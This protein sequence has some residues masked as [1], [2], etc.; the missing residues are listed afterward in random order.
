MGL[1]RSLLGLLINTV[2]VTTVKR[3]GLPAT[4]ILSCGAE[5]Y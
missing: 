1:L 2:T 3:K 4:T 5:I